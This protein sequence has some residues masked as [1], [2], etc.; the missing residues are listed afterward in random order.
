MRVMI[1]LSIF[2]VYLLIKINFIYLLGLYLDVIRDFIV[3]YEKMLYIL[4]VFL[5]I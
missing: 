1:I 3:M 4:G 5:K 2:S